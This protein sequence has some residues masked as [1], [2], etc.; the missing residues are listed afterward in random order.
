M[1]PLKKLSLNVNK[2]EAELCRRSFYFFLKTF[3]H[4]LVQDEPIYNWHIKYICDVLQVETIRIKKRLPALYDVIIFNVP[5][6]STKSTIIS[7]AWPIYNWIMDPTIKVISGSC[8]KELSTRD[9]VSSRDIIRSDKFKALFPELEI[10][11]DE[12]NKAKYKNTN[13]GKRIATSVGSTVMGEHGHIVMFDDPLN[14]KEE[15]SDEK[16]KAANGTVDYV[17]S[18]RKIKGKV[19]IAVLVMQRLHENDP[20][21]H[22]LK[23]K[24][25]RIKHICLPAIVS[26]QVK[27]A[28]LKD[29][30]KDGLLDPVRSDRSD[31]AQQKA[32]LGSYGYANQYEQNPS[33]EGG[34][35]IK[36]AWFGT[37]DMDVLQTKAKMK[38][39][40]LVWN[41]TIDGAYTSDPNNAQTAMLAYCIF[42]REMYIRDV[43][44]WWLELPDLIKSINNFA[45]VNGYNSESSIYV[46]PKA[47]G[48]PIVQTMKAE[49][50][51]NMII[52][53]APSDDKVARARSVSPFIEAR[54]VNLLRGAAFVD[55]FT[56]QCKLFPN[57]KLKDKVDTLVMAIQRH[58]ENKGGVLS[59]GYS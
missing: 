30:Y 8:T 13:G 6:G 16:I 23:N 38:G 35:I 49:T 41:Y 31:L 29:E 43:A 12:D 53:K 51:L 34:G 4:V 28:E 36:P 48:L 18:T 55:D 37:F 45:L 44:G 46:E 1:E 15:V 54:R 57:G 52:D 24:A 40:K 9:A 11:A 39:E 17:F 21:G 2:A 5:P 32:I 14:P 47:S 22:L 7:Q 27:P 25:L 20:T 59:V 3:W 19:A 56:A 42:E 50:T 26:D 58:N 10:K 33:P